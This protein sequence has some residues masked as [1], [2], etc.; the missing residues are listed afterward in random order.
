MT[1]PMDPW[2]W[3]LVVFLILMIWFLFKSLDLGKRFRA[4]QEIRQEHYLERKRA[5]AAAKAA[6]RTFPSSNTATKPE[7]KKP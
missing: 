3:V 7:V 5:E 6:A 2:P 4:R 1:D